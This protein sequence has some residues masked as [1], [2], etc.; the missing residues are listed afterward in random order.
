MCVVARLDAYGDEYSL[1]FSLIVFLDDVARFAMHEH[2]TES[3]TEERLLG[4]WT[5]TSIIA[6]TTDDAA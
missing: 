4:E 3:S 1:S 5:A 2:G 6:S